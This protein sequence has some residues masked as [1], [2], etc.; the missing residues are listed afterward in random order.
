[1]AITF[2]STRDDNEGGLLW[3]KHRCSRANTVGKTPPA[4]VWGHIY[5][6]QIK[7]QP[8]T[9]DRRQKLNRVRP[10]FNKTRASHHYGEECIYAHRCSV[11]KEDHGRCACPS[12]SQEGK[13]EA[14]CM[15]VTR[16]AI[17]ARRAMAGV[18]AHPGA[19]K[20]R[21]RLSACG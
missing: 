11:C 14:V 1:M 8:F 13:K 21:G 7:G 17:H 6:T 20:A 5:I 4:G 19:R 12:R 15:R 3:N 10:L 2:L 9:P 18:H 16:Q